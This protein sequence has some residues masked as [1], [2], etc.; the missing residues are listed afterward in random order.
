M[1]LDT[2]KRFEVEQDEGFFADPVVDDEVGIAYFDDEG[3]PVDDVLLID[4]LAVGAR[5][6]LSSPGTRHTVRRIA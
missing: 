6:D 1:N 2:S 3:Y 4:R 5:I